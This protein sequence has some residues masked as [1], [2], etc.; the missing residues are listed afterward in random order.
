MQVV[1]AVAKKH[2]SDGDSQPLSMATLFT[3]A[4]VQPSVEEMVFR[5]R[6]I[7]V[8][9]QIS[10]DV[11]CEDA[12]VTIFKKLVSEGL[13]CAHGNIDEEVVQML[14]GQIS[15]DRSEERMKIRLVIGSSH[16]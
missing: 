5:R 9:M 1:V 13:Y 4:G 11:S 10:S 7:E 2:Q 14:D 12:I 3:P 15:E 8:G 6:A 16:Y